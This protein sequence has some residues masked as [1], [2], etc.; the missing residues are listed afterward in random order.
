MEDIRQTQSWKDYLQDKGWQV[1]SIRAEDGR[2]KMN[3]FIVPLGL[4]GLKMMKIQRSD[5]DPNWTEL[6]KIK[7]EHRVVS[8][9]I[10]PQRVQ[11]LLGY[12]MAGYR[13]SKVPYLAT[14]T[15]LVDL[16]QTK[17]QLWKRLSENARRQVVKNEKTVIEEVGPEE[18]FFLWKKNSKVWTMKL[19][20]LISI[21]NRFKGKGKLI[22]S[23][24]GSE[25]HSGL[26]ILHTSDMANYY[27]TWT[28]EKGRQSGAHYKLVWE[29]MLRAKKEGLSFFDLEGVYDPRWPQKRWVGFT[30]FKRRFGGAEKVFP[31]SFFRWL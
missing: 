30:E 31:G 1:V 25:F 11:D 17:E 28:S 19:K 8:S 3:A 4:F 26:L 27:Q 12:R 5:Y 22:V 24:T 29:E 9:V 7:R 20:E 18:F 2:H 15:Y 13:L 10:E 21:I 23:R 16:T 14:K 6:K